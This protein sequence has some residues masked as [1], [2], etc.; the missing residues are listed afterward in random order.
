MIDLNLS[1]VIQLAIVLS[2]MVILSQ[3]VFKPFLSILQER[4]NRVERAEKGA[5]EFQQKTEELMEN[6]RE[7][8]GA[9][10][11]QAAAIRE[12]IRKGSLAKEME[13]LQKA[14]EEANRL[15]Q[16][17][18]RKINVETETARAG[19][20]FQAQNLSQKIA[21]KILGRSLQ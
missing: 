13:I 21:E 5:T 3:V 11:V 9:A 1:M 6:Y 19:L 2:L 16:A 7:A 15:I 14:V 20:Q 17:M 8:I 10:Q 4:K 12:E 18:K